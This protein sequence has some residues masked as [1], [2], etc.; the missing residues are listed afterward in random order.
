MGK[1]HLYVF[2]FSFIL[3]INLFPASVVDAGNNSQ[4]V[5]DFYENGVKEE[6]VVKDNQEVSASATITI[7]DIVKMVFSF[8]FVLG[9][10]YFL[11]R[12][13]KGKNRFAQGPTNI[14]MLGGAS[15]GQNRSIQLVK[16]GKRVL[17]LGVGDSVQLLKEIDEEEE[18]RSILEKK[19]ELSS[20]PIEETIKQWFAQ[21]TFKKQKEHSF[22]K[23]LDSILRTRSEQMRELHKKG[24]AKNE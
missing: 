7:F 9:L 17:V 13:L 11:M 4:T 21:K 5:K 10:I 14:E 3:L 6:L 19:E 2:I 1:R 18:I 24:N 20:S 22:K 15:L 8:L 12:F 16:V 23:E